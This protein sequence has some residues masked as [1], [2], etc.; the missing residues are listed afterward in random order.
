M[1]EIITSRLASLHLLAKG[2]KRGGSLCFSSGLQTLMGL[3]YLVSLTPFHAICLQCIHTPFHR[4]APSRADSSHSCR[5]IWSPYCVLGMGYSPEPTFPWITPCFQFSQQA[6]SLGSS[7][8]SLLPLVRPK[9]RG[10]GVRIPNQLL[11]WGT[12]KYVLLS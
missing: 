1:M 12:E 9:Q 4:S 10:F 2:E 3:Y 11:L 7:L 8:P 5:Q 6:S